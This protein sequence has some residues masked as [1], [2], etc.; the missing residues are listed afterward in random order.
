MVTP[1]LTDP[2]ADPSVK[3]TTGACPRAMFG[4]AVPSVAAR[5]IAIS[6]NMRKIPPHDACRREA[7]RCLCAKRGAAANAY[8]VR[9]WRAA[10]LVEAVLA[11]GAF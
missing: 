10:Y 8:A 3:R 7:P 9:K 11:A 5:T 6:L 1:S 4:I 2:A